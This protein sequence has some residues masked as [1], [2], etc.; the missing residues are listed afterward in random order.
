MR[1]HLRNLALFSLTS[2]RRLNH[3]LHLVIMKGAIH[4]ILGYENIYIEENMDNYGRF[5]HTMVYADSVEK[6]E[7][8]MCR[9]KRE[10]G[11]V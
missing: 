5:A 3:N 6:L 1:K 11:E 9:L 8:I 10:E 4:I 2:R 7:Q